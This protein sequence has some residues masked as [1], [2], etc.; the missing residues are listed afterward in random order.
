MVKRILLALA[1][2]AS[3]GGA[4]VACNTPSATSNPGSSTSG[5]TAPSLDTGGSSGTGAS[6]MPSESMA[7]PS[8]S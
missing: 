5:G 3:L 2:A 8:G 7:V 6:E 4:V 1:L